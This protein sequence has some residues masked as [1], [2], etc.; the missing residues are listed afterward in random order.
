MIDDDKL[1]RDAAR[2]LR[3]KALLEDELVVEAFTKLEAEYLAAWK[4]S[5]PDDAAG[6]ERVWIA[7]N[8][9]G[10]VRDH[11]GRFVADGKLAERQLQDLAS[12][13]PRQA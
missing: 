5:D 6:R 8:L 13:T 2:G 9:L 3:A 11:L 4:S 10:K 12:L 7:V 1:Q